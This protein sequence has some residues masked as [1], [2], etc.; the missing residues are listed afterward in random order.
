MTYK[1][2]MALPFYR[3]RDFGGE[4]KPDEII[5][6]VYE[7]CS[8]LGQENDSL[9]IAAVDGL[10]SGDES[11]PGNERIRDILLREQNEHGIPHV[12]IATSRN[13]GKTGAL[14]GIFSYLLGD[15][16]PDAHTLEESRKSYRPDLDETVF[17]SMDGDGQ[18]SPAF[19]FNLYPGMMEAY[20]QIGKTERRRPIKMPRQRI[21]A[22]DVASLVLLR[23]LERS[24]GGG[25]IKSIELPGYREGIGLSRFTRDFQAGGTAMR[26]RP[27]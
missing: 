26:G 7:E 11:M 21:E 9:I 14:S 19:V 10:K 16:V 27:V 23:S 20:A 5:R 1:H 12:V 4:Y 13:R 22:E 15:D 24:I 6:G 8:E 25:R 2:V 18:Q 3:S 17:Y